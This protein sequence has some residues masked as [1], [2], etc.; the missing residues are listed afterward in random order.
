M[1]GDEDDLL[2]ETAALSVVTLRDLVARTAMP[3]QPE[4]QPAQSPQDLS[5]CA[6]PPPS[7]R[8]TPAH[9]V[10]AVAQRRRS[11]SVRQ[12]RTG[13]GS[14]WVAKRR[15]LALALLMLAVV[16]QPWWWNI[17]DVRAHTGST[18][19]TVKVSQ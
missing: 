1:A 17:G 4:S 3:S 11:V 6:P 13:E 8:K 5:S 12:A 16:S 2:A 15:L 18:P 9:P 19:R 14:R 10:P 7:P